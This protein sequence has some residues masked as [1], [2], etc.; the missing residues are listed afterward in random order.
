MTLLNQTPKTFSY[1][2]GNDRSKAIL[3]D[4]IT[5]SKKQN[6]ALD[7][8]LLQGP[9]GTGKST[10]AEA[11]ANEMGVHYEELN[12]GNITSNTHDFTHKLM[13]LPN[14][15]I[16]FLD[17]CHNLPISFVEATIYRY[18]DEN[19]LFITYPDMIVPMNMD[20]TITLIFATTEPDKMPVPLLNRI[21]ITI[22][23]NSYSLTD[24]KKI[25]EVN[26][27]GMTTDDETLTLIALSSRGIPREVQQTIKLLRN[28]VIA[29]DIKEV[30]IETTRTALSRS[31]IDETGLNEIDRAYL[32]ALYYTFNNNPTGIDQLAN[33][34]GENKKQL[35]TRTEPF[36]FKSNLILKTSRGR[37]VSPEGLKFMLRMENNV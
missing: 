12:C 16:L 6:K 4:A 2:I 18:I 23:L 30:T 29:H 10:F 25:A 20:K 21:N 5:S 36:L 8:I 26:L 33:V 14:N 9:S 15:A 31:G 27:H 7:H 1:I 35:L 17:E 28:Y 3:Q 19:K 34:L 37:M 13:K 22:R 11:I 24:L 32:H